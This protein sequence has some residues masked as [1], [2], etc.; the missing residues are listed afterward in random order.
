M[1]RT[2]CTFSVHKLALNMLLCCL[3]ANTF[4]FLTYSNSFLAITCEHISACYLFSWVNTGLG[5]SKTFSIHL[6]LDIF[7]PATVFFIC[8]FFSCTSC[9]TWGLPVVT[10]C[11]TSSLVED[12][13]DNVGL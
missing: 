5:N 12:K 11:C 6:D 13:T 1:K 9:G 2:D 4:L 10:F 8:N 7:N 3:N